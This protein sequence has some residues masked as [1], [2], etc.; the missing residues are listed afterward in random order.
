M[1]PGVGDTRVVTLCLSGCCFQLPLPSY[2]WSLLLMHWTSSE[3]DLC[4]AVVR[5]FIVRPLQVRLSL[6]G[7]SNDGR[8]RQRFPALKFSNDCAW[9]YCITQRSR[10]LLGRKT[11][12]CFTPGWTRAIIR[13]TSRF[14]QLFIANLCKRLAFYVPT[15]FEVFSRSTS[16][17]YSK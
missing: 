17:I 3:P 8:G 1:P 13:P 11:L 15:T 7:Q 5:C 6:F 9:N 2:L 4:N 12:L 16:A 10:S 14:L